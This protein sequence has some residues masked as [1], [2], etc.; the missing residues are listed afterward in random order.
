[1]A[2]GGCGERQGDVH[3][4]CAADED[5]LGCFFLT[6]LLVEDSSAADHHGA[7]GG[8]E[9]AGD[10]QDSLA[11]E[12]HAQHADTHEDENED[13]S[14]SSKLCEKMHQIVLMRD[15]QTNMHGSQDQELQSAQ[16]LPPNTCAPAEEHA[17]EAP[18]DVMAEVQDRV[19]RLQEA[20]AGAAA[21]REQHSLLAAQRAAEQQ[22]ASSAAAQ[23]AAGAECVGSSGQEEGDSA[24]TLAADAERML[25]RLAQEKAEAGEQ[26]AK[27]AQ[28]EAAAAAQLAKEERAAA[29]AAAAAAER[30]AAQR[31]EEQ[32]A[33]AA[34]AAEEQ[35][36]AA[37]AAA[38]LEEAA[39]AAADNECLAAADNEA[40]ENA[41]A[42][43]VADGGKLGMVSAPVPGEGA[44]EEDEE[45]GDEGKDEALDG[46][47]L[48]VASQTRAKAQRE[49]EASV[50]ES[51]RRVGEMR[52]Q[53]TTYMEQLQAKSSRPRGAWTG[54]EGLAEDEEAE[55][56]ALIQLPANFEE[57]VAAAAAHA[58]HESERIC[59]P[60]L[61]H[62]RR[63]LLAHTG[64][65]QRASTPSACPFAP[66][67]P[68]PS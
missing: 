48:E 5:E 4:A 29:E 12:H 25:A 58:M 8:V 56:D 22:L 55:H 38:K 65:L 16:A 35:S 40:Q 36:A 41:A 11:K 37:A 23:T 30:A 18:R 39:R 57:V 66:S 63:T 50:E 28:A 67:P 21:L 1:M 13:L 62:L 51:G 33:A 54:R 60:L 59:S 10:A 43:A 6:G 9:G 52:Q 32:E 68:S 7:E 45:D 53:L 42:E 17:G 15:M 46:E 26:A 2:G 44:Q 31:E 49:V 19:E 27:R 34:R 24:A 47:A 61:A 3:L 20:A 14:A 64:P